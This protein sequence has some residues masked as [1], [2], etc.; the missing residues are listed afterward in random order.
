MKFDLY[1]S[2]TMSKNVEEIKDE[3]KEFIDSANQDL[4]SRGAPEGRGA[5]VTGW[6]IEGDKISLNITSE[7]YVRAH[8]ALIRLKKGI[9]DTL[10]K[11]HKVGAR[12]AQVDEY[13]ITFTTEKDPMDPVTIPFISDISF[14]ANICTLT[15]KDVT[16]EFLSHNYI[17]RMIKLVNEKV[18][19]QYYEGKSEKWELMWES[20]PKEPVWNKDPTEVMIIND[21]LKMG[22]EKGKWFFR[23]E[24]AA[25]VNAMKEI[26]VDEI[27]APLGFQEIIESHHVSFD[28]WL[29]TGHIEGS[30]NELYYVCEPKT[31]DTKTWERF[32]DLIKITRQ[33]PKDE[34]VNL[35]AAPNAGC[36]YAQCPVIYWSFASKVIA[37]ESL[38]VL[39]YDRTAN[40]NRYESG[41]RH[42]IERVDEFHRIEPTYIGTPEQLVELREKM[43]DRYKYVFNEI[44]ELDW[45]MAWVTPWYLEQAGQIDKDDKKE[46]IIGTIDFEA[47]LPYR[48]TREDSEWLEFQNLSI[49]GDKFIKPFN[50]KAQKAEL[51]SGCSGIGLER[52][53]AAFLAQKGLEFDKWPKKFQEKIGKMPPGI[54]FM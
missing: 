25:V 11:K 27:L 43:I 24:A 15:L 32:R 54:K 46:K 49:L 35:I 18:E 33:V 6:S 31:R 23:P 7:Q 8:D 28:I 47:Y 1:G 14:D 48:G 36:C 9:G 52:W 26:A 21:W 34:L 10:G 40:S 51:W 39:V 19:N 2:L 22:P 4:L 53:T 30:P 38:P 37:D 12:S 50:I 5:K 3:I 29:K 20:G 44:L 16:E 42:G 41:G 13:L 17:D 45:R